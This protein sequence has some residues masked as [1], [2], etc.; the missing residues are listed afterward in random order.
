MCW[1]GPDA[2]A[3]RLR[4]LDGHLAHV[5]KHWRNYVIAGPMR[6]PGGERLIGSLLL[7]LAEDEAAAWAICRG[8]PYFTNGQF[9]E[10]QV[11]HF[12][13]SIGLAIGGKIWESAD[14]IRARAAGG[15]ADGQTGSIG[16]T[17]DAN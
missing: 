9:A 8:D 10:V 14:A 11:K 3:L 1:D 16:T 7:V 12:T 6:E 15:P 17:G 5:E 2:A 4:D 13:Q